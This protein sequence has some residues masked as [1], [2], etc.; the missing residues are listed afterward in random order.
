[1][2]DD[3]LSTVWSAPNYCYRCG[4]LASILEVSETLQR[5]FNMFD[6]SDK[7]VIDD[8]TLPD[9]SRVRMHAHP[10]YWRVGR[11]CG[12]RV[13]PAAHARVLFVVKERER[14]VQEHRGAEEAR[15]EKEKAGRPPPPP[16]AAPCPA[17]KGTRT[18]VWE[19]SRVRGRETRTRG[20]AA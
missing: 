15:G 4:N 8:P 18:R 1:M 12:V 7:S 17:P 6:P 10:M 9:T 14:A 20:L 19:R 5:T 11:S 3:A 13:G 2:F 16:P